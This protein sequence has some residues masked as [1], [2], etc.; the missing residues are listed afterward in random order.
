MTT[1]A[2][3]LL[4]PQTRPQVVQALLALG[5]SEISG[6][7]GITGTM[8]KTAYAGAR[9]ASPESLRRAADKGLPLLAD[10]LEPYWQGFRAA[11]GA[12]FGTYLH[13]RSDEV[14]DRLLAAADQRAHRL[15]GP[16]A[17]AYATFR[18]KAK[19]HVV[20]ALPGLGAL[21]EQ[22]AR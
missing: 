9:K 8:M 3:T 12:G 22:H 14:S 2:Q 15:E 20:A 19:E 18:G 17:K 4:A 5:D 7:K 16:L 21:I 1:L 6:K 13:G 11:G 10:T